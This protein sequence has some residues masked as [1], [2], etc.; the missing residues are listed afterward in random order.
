MIIKIILL[1]VAA[2]AFMEFVA[3]SNR[4]YVMHGFLWSLHKNHHLTDIAGKPVM[5][6]N[7][8]F[9]LIFAAP[10]IILI[11]WGLSA[12]NPYMIAI[13]AAITLYGFIYF[14]FHGVV[15]RQRLPFFT[16]PKSAYIKALKKAHMAHHKPKNLKDFNNYG[17]LIFSRRYFK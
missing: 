7:D 1:I 13:G 15:Y 4:K 3:W 6:K 5:Q 14:I 17:L 12:G 8:Y 16:N 11:I 10:V 9:F 2:F